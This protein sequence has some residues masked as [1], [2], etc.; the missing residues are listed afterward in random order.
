MKKMY[1]FLLL[2]LSIFWVSGYASITM[3]NVKKGTSQILVEDTDQIRKISPNN[4][5]PN[6]PE[7][8]YE[9]QYSMTNRAA[10]KTA[11]GFCAFDGSWTAETGT[12]YGLYAFNTYAP[13]DI[14]KV[15]STSQPIDAGVYYDGYY[16]VQTSLL[17]G[18]TYTSM[19]FGRFNATTGNYEEIA[20]WTASKPRFTDF[21]VDYSTEPPQLIG[22]Q[23][24]L[25]ATQRKLAKINMSNG[26]LTTIAQGNTSG[27]FSA[28][29]C[30][31]DGTVY[32][33]NSSGRL[34][35]VSRITGKT[36]NVGDASGIVP[37]FM[38][39]MEFD[40]TDGKLYWAAYSS[41]NEGKFGTI[42]LNT[43]VFT[44]LGKLGDN[45]QF[46]GLYIPFIIGEP[47]IAEKVTNFQLTPNANG[48]RKA[49]LSWKNP[50]KDNTGATLSS[51]FSINI[52]R[53]NEIVKTVANQTAGAESS[54]IDDVPS[55]GIYVYKI[56][57]ENEFGESMSVTS[58]SFVGEDVP[59][60]PTSV[61]LTADGTKGIL[62]WTPP[63]VGGSNGWINTSSLT[64]KIMRNPGAVVVAENATGNTYTDNTIKDIAYQ[65]Y[66][67]QAKTSAGDGGIGTSNSLNIGSPLSLPYSCNFNAEQFPLWTVIDVND[68]WATWV[69]NGAA[70]YQTFG[71]NDADDWLMSPPVNMAV[72]K[73][74]L[75]FDC[76]SSSASY[77]A[78]MKVLYGKGATI[79]AQVNEL[80]DY[81]SIA[82]MLSFRKIIIID[83]KEAG[84]YNLGFYVYSEANNSGLIVDELVLEAMAD[85]DLQATA[86]SGNVLPMVGKE[87]VYNVTVYN[88]GTLI[89]NVY[90]VQLVDEEGN[91][92]AQTNVVP[93]ININDTKIVALNW[94]P[95]NDG[96]T[97]IRGKVVLANDQISENNISPEITVDIQPEGGDE[98]VMIGEG[99]E[100]AVSM[101]FNFYYKSG[102]SQIIY[103]R[104]EIGLNEGLIKK[105]IYPYNNASFR[106]VEITKPVKIYMANTVLAVTSAGWIPQDGFTQVFDGTVT[107]IKEGKGQMIITLDTPFV[108]TGGNLCVMNI[109]PLEQNFVNGIN[110]YLTDNADDRSIL[111]SND[112]D[113]FNWTQDGK[114]S[115]KIPQTILQIAE[116][117]SCKLVG[118]VKS[119]DVAIEGAKMTLSPLGMTATTDAEGNYTFTDI[120]SDTY[121]ITAVKYGYADSK[122]TGVTV[123]E[124]QTVTRNI[125][126]TKLFKYDV[127]GIVKDADGINIEGANVAISG[128]ESHQTT[129]NADG[130]F[131]VANVYSA[132]D[133]TIKV[134][135]KGY[136]NHTGTFSV[137]SG[138][139][140][141]TIILNAVPKPAE[142]V[143]AN[144]TEHKVDV[145]WNEPSK[146]TFRYDNGVAVSGLN[147]VY[148]PTPY[149]VMGTVHR[150]PAILNSMSWWTVGDVFLGAPH[151]K[152]N[153][154]VF[155]LDEN[156]EPTATV[157]FNQMDVPNKD[158]QWTSFTFPTQ[159]ECPRG[160]M[161]A[162]GYLGIMGLGHDSGMDADWPFIADGSYSSANYMSGVFTRMRGDMAYNLMVRAEGFEIDGTKTNESKS[163]KGYKVWRFAEIDQTF[164]N[165]WTALTETA[166][167]EL[168]YTDNSWPSVENGTYKY[169]VRTIYSG[170]V[171]STPALSN[172]VA[173]GME[174]SV[175]INIT[176]N[177]LPN[178]SKDAV[179][180]LTNN[181]NNP[182]HIYTGTVDAAGKSI[183]QNVWKG[184]YRVKI[185]KDG[186][187]TINATNVELTTD[188]P[189]LNYMLN[190]IVVIPFNLEIVENEYPSERV[191][192]WNVPSKSLQRYEVY[193]NGV[194]KADVMESSYTFTALENGTYSAGVKAVYGSST[195][196]MVTI[197][198]N[199]T[200]QAVAAAVKGVV[201][202]VESIA[203]ADVTVKITG[204]RTYTTTTDVTG[205][206]NFPAVMA[207]AG[208][209][210]TFSKSG[211]GNQT[212]SF[213]VI[214]GTDLDLGTVI[215][216]ENAY[217]PRKVTAVENN[218]N[219]SITWVN[220]TDVAPSI[221]RYDDG[222]ATNG[223]G[224]PNGDNMTIVGNVF[225]TPAALT[226]MS[227]VTVGDA[228]KVN[229][230]VFDLTSNGE[231]TNTILFSQLNYNNNKSSTSMVWNSLKFPTEV[232][233]PR[234]FFLAISIATPE[235]GNI[236]LGYDSGRSTTWPFRPNVGYY[237]GDYSDITTL[238][239]IGAQFPGNLMIRAEGYDN[240]TGTNLTKSESKSLTGYKVWR[241]LDADHSNEANWTL[242][243]E[244]PISTLTTIDQT[245]SGLAPGDYKY[246]VRALYTGDITS[247][248]GF[249]N[250]INKPNQYTISITQV[251]NGTITVMS[252]ANT[253]NHGD[254]VVKNTELTIIATPESTG[255]ALDHLI[256]NGN[257][258]TSNK[259]IVTEDLNISALFKPIDGIADVE[260]MS[261]LLYPNPVQDIL[262]IDGEYTSLEIYNMTGRLMISGCGETTINVSSL[263]NGTYVVKAK[264]H[265]KIATYKMIK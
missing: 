157:L 130:A 30:S 16:Y 11:Y 5:R 191:F 189:S 158:D 192:S 207:G 119:A 214:A 137:T 254:K 259:Y 114:T 233:C 116:L 245:W 255:Y 253:I 257:A 84:V 153:V 252:G 3:G 261:L 143:V 86:V 63:T 55:S 110:F 172:M 72:G 120:P 32:V 14:T 31:Y 66:I 51:A 76:Y 45:A 263:P 95:E 92:L 225:R 121:S 152:V 262:H 248:A 188:A 87:Y 4:D 159:I 176:T 179:I 251:Q 201:K 88:G 52:Y 122:V 250:V 17:E 44:S 49:S 144:A 98:M 249:S 19:K 90:S 170:D 80:A 238:Q 58:Q 15:W 258:I 166:I 138:T 68:D 107:L 146:T 224:S 81:T 219:V 123:P 185:V 33:M 43:G 57:V 28:I 230:F 156:G 47:G 117:G 106:D 154:F 25:S 227:W 218:D 244:T 199:V 256:I 53:N 165:K 104:S 200:G 50:S 125:T 23:Y 18:G 127:S 221:F 6:R 161:V 177:V 37:K 169:A 73:Y 148:P 173:R 193:L 29:A 79:E 222:T 69:G 223:L 60:G 187:T 115:K 46:T 12:S 232:E 105:I 20:D 183:I 54:Y 13:E 38:Q 160:F 62:N 102:V 2:S 175:T 240:S 103:L 162:I 75:S 126:M 113:E 97:K 239:Y 129:T 186:Y 21:T 220:G 59:K 229:L 35:T 174:T 36:S 216:G 39:S 202:D 167:K 91:V 181:D 194:K 128:Y 208:Y 89:Q 180:T 109:H 204:K 210:A 139:I 56:T 163:I 67:V 99:M 41:T 133:Y 64:Y 118:T 7:A 213:S 8:K 147:P 9:N 236:A 164:E 209:T 235:A 135:K 132:N 260:N 77:P 149:G 242:L 195:T 231:P 134:A 246:A 142:R 100:E 108:Y 124:Y 217:T 85:N 178:D 65:S 206:F 234:G 196:E 215:I 40:H 241:L 112:N 24:G 145:T 93:E 78:K 34:Q 26:S 27:T 61:V 136:N 71:M 197:E 243:T 247:T 141:P 96:I 48:E 237:N 190:E 203:V 171:M 74:R 82:N 22:L 264:Y 140:I 182:T 228:T 205:A 150:T 168:N 10:G 111:Y 212:R 83:I 265:D 131:V 211:F 101:P 184:T 155:D 198:F 42:D 226:S 1:L 94:V 70:Q 151:E